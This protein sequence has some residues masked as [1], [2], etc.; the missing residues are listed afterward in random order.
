MAKLSSLILRHPPPA[1]SSWRSGAGGRGTGGGL[2]PKKPDRGAERATLD[3]LE[4][5]GSRAAEGRCRSIASRASKPIDFRRVTRD[6]RLPPMWTRWLH[7]A[8]RGDERRFTRARSPGGPR[9]LDGPAIRPPLR[10]GEWG[11]TGGKPFPR[12]GEWG[13]TGGKPFPRCGEWGRT[14][15]KPFPRCGEWGRTGVGG[16]PG[17]AKRP[18]WGHLVASPLI[19][20]RLRGRPQSPRKWQT[21]V[22]GRQNRDESHRFRDLEPGWLTAHTLSGILRRP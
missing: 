3:W 13:R 19:R 12:C 10:G 14:G 2:S 21:G 5:P 18:I 6:A 7:R 1:P 20:I 22:K 17:P 16:S 9:G 8:V 15:G 11:R 4:R